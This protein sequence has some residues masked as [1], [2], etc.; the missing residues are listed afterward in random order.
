[1]SKLYENSYDLDKYNII[2][3]FW[4]AIGITFEEL[5]QELL[6]S[7]K[8]TYYLTLDKNFMKTK[9]I[10]NKKNILVQIRDCIEF[11]LRYDK[12]KKLVMKIERFTTLCQLQKLK[13]NNPIY[14]EFSKSGKL[15]VIID[16]LAVALNVKRVFVTD[17]STKNDFDLSLLLVMKNG[18]TFYE[19]YNFRQCDASTELQPIGMINFELHKQLL[20]DFNFTA[21]KI[22]LS[23]VHRAIVD[24]IQV[25][26]GK[27]FRTLG[28]FY[29]EAFDY[30]DPIF[31]LD[32][33]KAIMLKLED[34]LK[35]PTYPWF[36]MVDCINN[37]GCCLEKYY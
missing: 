21:V 30:Y 18:K 9:F 22:I 36:A 19:K 28:E 20:R 6:K 26:L 4:I 31:L 33:N 7:N 17:S 29:S 23:P 3:G 16:K 14:A 32:D 34:I 13:F 1:M 24:K 27:E 25:T 5:I 35:T 37:I 2:G 10:L 8:K 11:S 12:Q 15:L